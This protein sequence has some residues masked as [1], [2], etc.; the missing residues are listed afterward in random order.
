[1]T[2][3]SAHRT[4]IFSI[5]VSIGTESAITKFDLKFKPEEE[6]ASISRIKER[7]IFDFERVTSLIVTEKP[8]GVI[9][10]EVVIKLS[11]IDL[12]FLLMILE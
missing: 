4:V 2:L 5:S 12:M 9:L 1:M 11:D 7:E 6:T 8:S 10:L 3:D